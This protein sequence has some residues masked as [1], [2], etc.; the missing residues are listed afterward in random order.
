MKEWQNLA[1]AVTLLAWHQATAVKTFRLNVQ[2]KLQQ[3]VN[4][5]DS[6]NYC[7]WRR[8]FMYY[9]QMRI[10]YKEAPQLNEISYK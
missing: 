3:E 10:R 2:T 6:L 5:S 7:N 9:S 8:G 4:L 1:V